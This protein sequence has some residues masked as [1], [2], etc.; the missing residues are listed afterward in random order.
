MWQWRIGISLKKT[1]VIIWWT[2]R[3]R[4]F[5]E[6]SELMILNQAQ[7][8]RFSSW[9]ISKNK[10]GLLGDYHIGDARLALVCDPARFQQFGS[11]RFELY[12]NIEASLTKEEIFIILSAIH[13]YATD[14]K[15]PV[16]TLTPVRLRILSSTRLSNSLMRLSVSSG[17]S[18]SFL[19]ERLS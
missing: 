5:W 4:L 6:I 14:W 11:L 15:S 19:L 3:A 13:H 7:R 2:M 1:K 12:Q 9:C 8:G 10:V 18:S 16:R 17:S